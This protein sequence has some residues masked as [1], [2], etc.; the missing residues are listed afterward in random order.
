MM[1][2][3]DL[4]INVESPVPSA[5][6]VII[7]KGGVSHVLLIQ[8]DASQDH[9][10]AYGVIRGLFEANDFSAVRDN[11]LLL[12]MDHALINQGIQCN[13]SAAILN[14][15]HES[16]IVSLSAVGKILVFKKILINQE[17]V[18]FRRNMNG[19]GQGVYPAQLLVRIGAYDSL[20]IVMSGEFSENICEIS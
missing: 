2:I 9:E 6:P 20:K 13:V 1:N 10:K 17:S 14:V 7:E 16:K 3:R 19:L 8:L 18:V 12:N 11:E 5:Y 4:T 15:N